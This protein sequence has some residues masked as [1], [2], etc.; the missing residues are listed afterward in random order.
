MSVKDLSDRDT[1][2]HA[3]RRMQYALCNPDGV[4]ISLHTEFDGA[5]G[6]YAKSRRGILLDENSRRNYFD[7]MLRKRYSIRKCFAWV[8]VEKTSIVKLP[9]EKKVR[10]KRVRRVK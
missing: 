9:P 8:R 2:T 4:P 3:I 5:L 7:L 10:I 6:S 1:R